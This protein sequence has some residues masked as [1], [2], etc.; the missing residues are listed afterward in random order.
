V[1]V[2]PLSYPRAAKRHRHPFRVRGLARRVHLWFGLALGALFIVS[3]ITG[4]ILAFYP[5]LDR[6][7]VPALRAVPA[8]SRPASWQAVVTALHRDHPER[9]G[10]WRI[11]VT[12]AGGP[13]PV[14]YYQPVETAEQAFA[15][16]MLWLDPRDLRTIRA[17]F[18]GDYPSSWI[19]DLHWRLLAGRTGETVMGL[20]GIAL[21]MMLATGLIAWWPRPGQW[22]R[23]LH[24]KRRAVRVRRLYDWHKW[25][26]LAGAPVLLVVAVTGVLLEFPDQFRPAIGAISPLFRAPSPVVTPR[27]RSPLSLDQLIAHAMRRFPDAALAWIET[28]ARP[29]AALRINVARPSEPSRRF[30]R[31]NV[32]LDPWTGR[33][34][35]VRDGGNERAGDILLDWLHPLHGGEALGIAGRCLV[36]LSGLVA[37]GLGVTGWWRW[38]IRR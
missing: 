16:L 13:L 28:P 3:G 32:W 25:M 26:G 11:E 29:D 17:G 23:S 12:P 18:W 35:A 5:E 37:A 20:A 2:I 9:T 34:L 6:A 36:L 4:S 24:V 33:I 30:P 19:Y 27:P 7:L 1:A 10:A 8:G 15:P 38:A 14:R 22:R 21:V 31:T